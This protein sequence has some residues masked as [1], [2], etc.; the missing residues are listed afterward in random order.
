MSDM[1][2]ALYRLPEQDS[3]L[4]RLKANSIVVRRAIAPEKLQVLDWVRSHFS[5]PWVDEC[6]VAFARQP[7]TCYIALEHGKMIGFACYEATCRNFFGPTGVSPSAR[8]KGVGTA[9][10]MACMH[11]MRA[12]GYGYAIIGSAGPVDF[13]KRTLGAVEIENSTPGIYEGMLRAE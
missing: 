5:Q 1:L 2:V 6:D 12:D 9:L 10:L 4:E 8:G 11:A 7:V 13:Y 3:G